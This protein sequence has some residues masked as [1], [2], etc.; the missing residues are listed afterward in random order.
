MKGR[1]TVIKEVKKN[2]GKNF[3]G[4]SLCLQYGFFTYNDGSVEFTHRLVRKNKE[5]HTQRSIPFIPT[6]NVL[7]TLIKKF[8]EKND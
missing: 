6:L 1:F 8:E 4:Q 2:L 3:N 7:K 5:G